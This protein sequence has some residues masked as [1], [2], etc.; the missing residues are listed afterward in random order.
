MSHLVAIRTQVHELA[1]V[2][3]A[4]QR[5]QLPA[6]VNMTVKLFNA[7]V[8]G[9]AVR[10]PDWRFPVVCDLAHG[11]LQFDNFG[12]RWGAEAQLHRFLQAYAVETTLLQARRQGYAAYEQPL[13]DGSIRVTLQAGA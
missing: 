9:W 3:A 5:L 10:L 6:P 2:V 8:S 11:T 4:C 12:G 1:G 13:P 7:T